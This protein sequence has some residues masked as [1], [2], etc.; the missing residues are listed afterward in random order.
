M[1]LNEA[2]VGF[3]DKLYAAI[4]ML[5]LGPR[6]ASQMIDETGYKPDTVYNYILRGRE[7]G[8]L[9]IHDYVLVQGARA[10]QARY[11][12]QPEKPFGRPDAKLERPAGA[13][14]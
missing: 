8:V 2:P 7:H 5:M 13:A 12:V 14:V 10:P 11:A 4:A 9:Y 1:T 3:I 6:T